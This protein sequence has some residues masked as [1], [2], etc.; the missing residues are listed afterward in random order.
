[1]KNL[2]MIQIEVSLQ[3]TI[4]KRIYDPAH[5]SCWIY[6]CQGFQSYSQKTFFEIKKANCINNLNK[7]G[8]L[9]ILGSK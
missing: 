1:M 5:I 7:K 3:Q 8:R 9:F 6:K 4:D 2:A